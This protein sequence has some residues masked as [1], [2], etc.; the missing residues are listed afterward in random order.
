[1]AARAAYR[2]L[3]RAAELAFHGDISIHQA[4]RFQIREGFR[5]NASLS[6]SDSQI[7]ALLNHAKDVATILKENVVQGKK[8]GDAYKL[9]IHK[10]T[11]RGDNDTVKFPGGKTT[12]I[13]G[14]TCCS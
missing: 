5:H 6:P 7:P 11:E 3:L 4:A 1:M 2:N 13:D 12:K 10:H 8:D 14:K 9:R